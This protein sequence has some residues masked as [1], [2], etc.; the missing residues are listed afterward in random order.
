MQKK[1]A[2]DSPET[3]D[4]EVALLAQKKRASKPIVNFGFLMDS[5]LLQKTMLRHE[6]E[7][8]EEATQKID[9]SHNQVISTEEEKTQRKS[10]VSPMRKQDLRN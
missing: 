4:Q 2:F 5:H 6:Q 7:E 10:S 1:P 9:Y 8:E 3:V